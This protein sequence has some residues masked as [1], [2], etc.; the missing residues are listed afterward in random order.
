MI[1]CRP[2]LLLVL[3]AMASN[4]HAVVWCRRVSKALRG[5]KLSRQ[6]LIVQAIL[7]WFDTYRA[8]GDGCS[9]GYCT[10]DGVGAAGFVFTHP[11]AR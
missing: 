9:G 7:V 2:G 10:A 8:V 6:I 3:L 5:S 1:F 11:D 4:A